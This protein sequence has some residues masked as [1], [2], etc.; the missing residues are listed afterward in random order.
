MTGETG[1]I[2]N[3]SIDN[4]INLDRAERERIVPRSRGQY[5]GNTPDGRMG[6]IYH[7]DKDEDPFSTSPLPGG[8]PFTPR[9]PPPLPPAQI[10]RDA[11]LQKILTDVGVVRGSQKPEFVGPIDSFSTSL[12]QRTGYGATPEA[13][14]F[15]ST[16]A[17]M[18]NKVLN[19]LSG[20][21][22]SPAE[23]QRLMQQLPNESMSEVD[24]NAKLAN[25]ERETQTLVSNRQQGFQRAGFRGVGG[26]PPQRQEM[27]QNND[28]LGLFK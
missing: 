21:A 25:F 9:V 17:G 15:K 26:Q 4:L 5:V 22:I 11:E 19:L 8:Q 7:P 27:Q 12:K 10:D 24:F 14:I 1:P 2:H 13:A 16:V 3:T 18:R 20:A 23:A 28:P 6:V